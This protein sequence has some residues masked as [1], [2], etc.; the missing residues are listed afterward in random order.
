[1]VE[2]PSL[3]KTIAVLPMS[4]ETNDLTGP[5]MARKMF[6]EKVVKKGYVVQPLEETDVLLN[7]IGITDGGQLAAVTHDDLRNALNVEGLMYGTLHD[8]KYVML[9][10]YYKRKVR[11]SFR[12]TE[13]GTGKILWEEEARATRQQFSLESDE[14]RDSFA[15]QLTEKV[16]EILIQKNS[17]F[18][19][20]INTNF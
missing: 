7:N 4:N 14:A 16:I 9:G 6:A 19:N 12:F 2:D 3:P 10:V 1:M 17:R 18:F 15:R 8:F 20:Q 13:S 5:V 11:I